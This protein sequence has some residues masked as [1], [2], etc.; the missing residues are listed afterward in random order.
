M[1][2]IDIF[3][4]KVRRQHWLRSSLSPSGD[5]WIIDRMAA[6]LLERWLDLTVKPGRILILGSACDLLTS[7]LAGQGAD[8]VVASIGHRQDGA[9]QHFV[10]CDEDRLPFAD[11][12]FDAVFSINSLD[13][14]NDVPGALLLIRRALAPSGQFLGAFVGAGS[15]A[16]L[17]QVLQNPHIEGPHVA[18]THPQI[19]VRAAGDLLVRA[20]FTHAVA[21]ADQITTRYRSFSALVRDLRANGLS[22]ALTSRIPFRKKEAQ[23][24]QSAFEQA[25]DNDGRIEEQFCPIFLSARAPA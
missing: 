14:V 12:A 3:D 9:P 18:R 11:H 24:V 21:D 10:Q 20:G 2:E 22:N 23:G 5:R 17:R 6:E 15:L 13:T 25:H 4:R 1:N 16:H 7:A 19:E 8:L